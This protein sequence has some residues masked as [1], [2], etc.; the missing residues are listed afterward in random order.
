MLK[1]RLIILTICLLSTACQPVTRRR[2]WWQ[3]WSTATAR[4]QPPGCRRRDC[5]RRMLKR[6]PSQ[7]LRMTVPSQKTLE[8]QFLRHALRMTVSPASC[9]AASSLY[10]RRPPPPVP[11][12][13]RRPPQLLRPHRRPA[14]KPGYGRR[15]PDGDR[16]AA[17]CSKIQGVPAPLLQPATARRLPSA[18]HA[19]RDE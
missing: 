10:N 4:F 9:Q 19:A 12:R 16:P 14:P 3:A 18:V 1:S 11:R 17:G 5:P 7:S 15:R 13:C 8:S 2:A 6:D